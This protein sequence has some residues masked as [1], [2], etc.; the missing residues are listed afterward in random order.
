MST[1]PVLHSQSNEPP[2]FEQTLVGEQSFK[3]S[4]EHSS[5]SAVHVENTVIKIFVT[6]W[7]ENA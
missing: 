4:A 5:K 3:V 6:R 7:F 1:N 2:L